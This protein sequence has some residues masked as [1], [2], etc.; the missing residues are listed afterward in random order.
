MSEARDQADARS[1]AAT[2][3]ERTQA[4]LST[5]LVELERLVRSSGF[6]G[7][8][9][10]MRRDI[11]DRTY[12]AYAGELLRAGPLDLRIDASCIR[13]I[14]VAEAISGPH[15]RESM[16]LLRSHQIERIEF[17]E[18]LSAAGF[19]ALVDLLEADTGEIRELGGFARA[20]AAFA[21]GSVTINREYA[22]TA[23]A[24][25]E[26][27]ASAAPT[28]DLGVAR[29]DTHDP[30]GAAPRAPL[31]PEPRPAPPS[32]TGAEAEPVAA[33]PGDETTE[34][35]APPLE[36]LDL[37][38]GQYTVPPESFEPPDVPMP[39]P[40]PP[41]LSTPV[42]TPIHRSMPAPTSMPT[43]RPSS[44]PSSRP[45]SKPKPTHVVAGAEEEPGD[46]LSEKPT[47]E[48]DPL[49]APANDA[50][51][52]HL[53]ER[54]LEL[55]RCYEDDSYELLATHITEWARDLFE[56]E[57]IDDWYRAVLVFA[58][59]TVGSGG[60]SGLQARLA[61]SCC[62]KL[63]DDERLAYLIQ[64]ACSPHSAVS[65]RATQVLLTLGE[66]TVPMLVDELVSAQVS[67]GSAQLEGILIAL[68]E[69]ALPSIE[70]MIR[71]EV[72]PRARLAIRMAG[73]LQNSALT[74]VLIDVVEGDRRG[75]RRDA[76]RALIH[77]G[78]AEVVDKLIE[79]LAGR[80]EELRTLS[81][82]GLGAMSN[83]HA[84]R[85]LLAAM[86]KAL[87]ERSYKFARELIRA[88]GQLGT[89]RAVPKLVALLESRSLMR[90]KQLREI[91]LAALMAL[92]G[93]TGNE[94]AAAV[95]RA[96]RSRD[97]VIR[98][99]AERLVEAGQVPAPVEGAA[100]PPDGV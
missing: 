51:G 33:A 68:G 75:L 22:V 66:H 36:D 50:H 1:A 81:A 8:D 97:A 53:L 32:P 55:D 71:G 23:D 65:I 78:G 96:F 63:A 83:L 31:A 91:K 4:D 35:M 12:R 93:L 57:R 79:G 54:L 86:D 85:P 61:Q 19:Q 100:L 46:E 58:D 84:V 98:E 24:G 60:R 56:E 20:L 15:L 80:D 37:E 52:T 18:N 21:D 13:A 59:H 17:A 30:L 49:A 29:A 69:A 45:N 90:R 74:G 99:R 40:A 5:L 42:P 27:N 39:S 25:V 62:R 28:P 76:V 48:D 14:G 95:K 9:D 89:R 87:E 38:I 88:L 10:A 70:E 94:A 3:S 73:E 64:R 47:L 7:N 16:T 34:T 6:Y 67:G 26:A 77:I 11:L 72:E 2:R 43:A 82:L 41:E 44:K 92:D